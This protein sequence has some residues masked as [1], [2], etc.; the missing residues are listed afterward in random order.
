VSFRLKVDWISTVIV[1][2][3]GIDALF[4]GE[5]GGRMREEI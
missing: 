2:Q 1:M 3:N 4:D 5:D